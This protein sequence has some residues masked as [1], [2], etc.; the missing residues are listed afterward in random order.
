[1][2][3]SI[4]ILQL[5]VAP[6]IYFQQSACHVGIRISIFVNLSNILVLR[7]TQICGHVVSLYRVIGCRIS[8]CG[9]WM[10]KG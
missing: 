1:M 9:L 8:T 4:P 5:V 7:S 10:L 2:T 3:T 6:F